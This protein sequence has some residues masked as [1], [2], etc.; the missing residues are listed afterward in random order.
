M[1]SLSIT[2]SAMEGQLV[3]DLSAQET[4]VGQLQ[5]QLA[6]GNKVNQPSDN[7][8]AAVQIMQ[9]Q[10]F[11]T[12]LTQYQSNASDAIGWLGTANG[13]MNQIADQ[14]QQV[15]NEVL[16]VSSV[17]DQGPS[18]MN[19]LADQIDSARQS[20]VGLANANYGGQPLFAGT[21]SGSA[22]YDPSGDYLGSGSSPTRTVAPGVTIAVSVTGPS[23]F[24]SGTSGLLSDASGNLGVLAQ[25]SSDLRAGNVSAVLGTDLNNLD[26]AISQVTSQAA[27]VGAN[28]DH[29]QEMS[30]QAASS[31]SSV[32][33]DLSNLDNVDMANA[34]S[35]LTVQ[36]TSLQAALWATAQLGKASLVNY[37]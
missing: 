21:A 10:A 2:P 24:G 15:R 31:L 32:Q 33:G 4:G 28:Y 25:I 36:Q 16:S 34:M 6:S 23:V 26:T 3:A 35:Q 27:V 11:Q 37:L 30:Q 1:E 20:L 13:T 8:A 19:A 18:A 12:R 29:A 5:Q 9:L 17:Q 14:L 7:P 22:A